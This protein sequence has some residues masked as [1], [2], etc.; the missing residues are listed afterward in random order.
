MNNIVGLS[1]KKLKDFL[2]CTTSFINHVHYVQHNFHLKPEKDH[3]GAC[4]NYVDLKEFRREFVE[5]LVDTICEWVYSQSKVKII[6]DKLIEE[7]GRSEQNANSK[8]R[9]LAF[10]KFRRSKDENLTLQGQFGEL[11][12]FN[13]M[14]HFFK[15]VPL[16]RKM[17]ITTSKGH[18]RFGADAIHYKI[19]GEKNIIL[20]GESKAYTYDKKCKFATAF[21]DALLSI[22]ETYDNFKDEIDLYTYEDFLEPELEQ[23]A[24]AYKNGTL[25]DV[26]IHLVCIIAYNETTDLKRESQEQIKTDIINAIS[27]RCK[28]LKADIYDIFNGKEAMLARMNYIIFPF[29]EMRNLIEEFKKVIGK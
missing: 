17:P 22:L 19:E 6:I 11:L 8:I 14:Q 28:N 1:E 3:I 27:E 21:R 16:L 13:F 26:E 23:V 29:W 5:E 7:E 9:T 18:E 4:I 25:R 15:A 12:L 10:N 2:T 20:L 24:R